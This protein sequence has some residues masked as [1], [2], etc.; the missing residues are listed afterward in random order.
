MVYDDAS[1]DLILGFKHAD[2]TEAAP[3]F[4]DWMARAQ[5][6]LIEEADLIAPVPLH[7]SRLM[8]RQFNQS[9]LLAWRLGK[10]LG[11]RRDVVP[12]LLKR[13]RRTPP[14]GGLGG[15]GRKRNMAGAFAVNAGMRRRLE[16]ARVL[17]VDDVYTTG[18]TI[19]ACA[20]VLLRS[21]AKAVD[22]LTLARVV[23][24]SN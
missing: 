16:G 4:G 11:R 12:D 17:L 2:K 24:P 1:R 21:G 6:G 5:T 8:R 23:R 10:V 22:A 13:T 20:R 3:A 9:A 19:E 14:Q 7:W 15:A 18:A